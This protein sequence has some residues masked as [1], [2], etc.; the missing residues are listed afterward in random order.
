MQ[1]TSQCL[2]DAEVTP[3]EAQ[4]GPRPK[5]PLRLRPKRR[6]KW[7]PRPRPLSRASLDGR[8]VGAKAYDQLARNITND[9]GGR[10]Q[11]SWIERTL[12]EGYCGAYISVAAINAR[13]V[14]GETVDLGELSGCVSAMV[15]VAS[16][17]GLQ[18]RSRDVTP[19]LSDLLK[20]SPP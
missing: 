5:A 3:A 13:I 11:L 2:L 6:T 19:S 9:L 14:R 18:R 7:T 10:D 1:H 16:R 12:V 8:T 4:P 20:A 15:R 17:L